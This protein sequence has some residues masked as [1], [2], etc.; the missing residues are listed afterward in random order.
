MKHVVYVKNRLYH[1]ALAQGDSGMSPF[2]SVF[3]KSPLFKNLHV[4]GCDAWELDHQHRSG[5]WS[6]KAKKMMFVGVSDNKKG[7]VLF[8]PKTR[9]LVT[10][11]HATFD[12]SMQNRRCALR[13]FDLR[14]AKAGPGA[15]REETRAALHERCLYDES[16]PLL[17]Q[18]EYQDPV[19]A[20][21]TSAISGESTMMRKKDRDHHL[22][23]EK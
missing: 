22:S 23:E 19:R 18:D 2:Q 20:D 4:F 21:E 16:A 5:S 6:R 8:D 10:T 14:S 1:S 12:E 17:D 11:Y 15:S 9:K 3:G 13:D 7:W